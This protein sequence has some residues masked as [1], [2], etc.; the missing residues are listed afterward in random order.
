M[1]TVTL[2]IITLLHYDLLLHYY[3]ITFSLDPEGHT[4]VV[5]R[6]NIHLESRE[7]LPTHKTVN[8]VC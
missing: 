5:E 8:I 6:Q 1:P 7:V 4:C 2:L 3:T